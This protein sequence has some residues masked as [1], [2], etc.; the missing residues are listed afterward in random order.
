MYRFPAVMMVL[1]A[2]LALLV[3]CLLKRDEAVTIAW[4]LGGAVFMGLFGWFMAYGGRQVSRETAAAAVQAEKA[5]AEEEKEEGEEGEAEE[6]GEEAVEGEGGE[7]EE[8]AAG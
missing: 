4:V 2:A 3:S 1:G 7:T 8:S 5:E 6:K